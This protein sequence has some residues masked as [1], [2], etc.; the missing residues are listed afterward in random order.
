MADDHRSLV[1]IEDFVEA[2]G[3]GG[4]GRE[5][6][7]PIRWTVVGANDHRPHLETVAIPLRLR[8]PTDRK[9]PMKPGETYRTTHRHRRLRRITTASGN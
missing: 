3:V 5:V 1:A 7:A 6:I 4:E 2:R 9:H 8:A